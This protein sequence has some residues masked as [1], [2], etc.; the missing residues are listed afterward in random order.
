MLDDGTRLLFELRDLAGGAACYIRKGTSGVLRCLPRE[1]PYSPQY[2]SDA[3]CTTKLAV[4]V[5]VGR[6]DCP[7]LGY[8]SFGGGYAAIGAP[9]TSQPLYRKTGVVGECPGVAL[10]PEAELRALGPVTT[11][12]AFVAFHEEREPLLPGLLD[13]VVNVG[14]DGSRIW[15]GAVHDVEHNVRSEMLTRYTTSDDGRVVPVARA[16]TIDGCCSLVPPA[17]CPR[18]SEGLECNAPTLRTS[19]GAPFVT[20]PLTLDVFPLGPPIT[21]TYCGTPTFSGVNCPST[22]ATK[23]GTWSVGPAM[24]SGCFVATKRVTIGSGRL[25]STVFRGAGISF[26]KYVDGRFPGGQ[27]VIVDTQATTPDKTCRLLD[28]GD[29]QLRCVPGVV[30]E[31]FYTDASCTQMAAPASAAYVDVPKPCG[32][33]EVFPAGAPIAGGAAVPTYKLYATCVKFPDRSLREVG[34]AADPASF[35]VLP[36]VT[37]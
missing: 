37:D 12:A 20:N 16:G 1:L 18:I 6:S 8:A 28:L 13:A 19:D 3:T 5:L 24:P 33:H 36:I 34:A 30:T 7:P 10:G 29:G 2:Y 14:D 23:T 35:P 17:P 4:D 15:F 27:P 21:T 22:V 25:R 31:P 26:A 9:V 32:R 11:E